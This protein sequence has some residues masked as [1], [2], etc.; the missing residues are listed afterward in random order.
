MA[1]LLSNHKVPGLNEQLEIQVVDDPGPGGAHHVYQINREDGQPL[2]RIAF[3]YGPLKENPPNGI[4]IEALLAIC[5][6]RLASF[7]AGPF[8][9]NT[10]A[11]ALS[12]VRTAI[13]QLHAR[14][15]DRVA[16]GVEGRSET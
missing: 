14:T 16:R 11:E 6:D 13:D 1:R 3:Q 8:A 15:R 12:C 10:N 2:V 5:E 7:Q 4:S 9:C